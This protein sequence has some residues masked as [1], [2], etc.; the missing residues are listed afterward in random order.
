MLVGFI[1]RAGDYPGR[2][3][4]GRM[5]VGRAGDCPFS[6]CAPPAIRAAGGGGG[7]TG[8]E[9]GLGL[10]LGFGNGYEYGVWGMGL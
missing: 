4:I 5:A 1:D 8:L 2:W 3:H 7:A 9:M 10:S 6:I